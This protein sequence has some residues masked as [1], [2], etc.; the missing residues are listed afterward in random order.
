M[1]LP[2]E[3]SWFFC[4]ETALR[5]K[6]TMKTPLVSGRL[7]QTDDIVVTVGGGERQTEP[8]AQRK[9][10]VHGVHLSGGSLVR[11]LISITR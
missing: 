11:E 3:R 2:D 1:D 9:Y 8:E 7:L 5:R 10:T 6:T 4:A